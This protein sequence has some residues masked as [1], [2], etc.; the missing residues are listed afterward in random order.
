MPVRYEMSNLAHFH[1]PKREMNLTSL[2]KRFTIP[3]WI[4][5]P[6]CPDAVQFSGRTEK[7]IS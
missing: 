3:T 6:F 2:L 5:K 7:V 4:V 1:S